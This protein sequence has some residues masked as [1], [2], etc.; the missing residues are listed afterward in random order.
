MSIIY[1]INILY[2]LIL[3]ITCLCLPSMLTTTSKVCREDVECSRLQTCFQGHHSNRGHCTPFW[4]V[5][6]TLCH[7]R[8]QTE[9]MVHEREFW[10]RRAQ[11]FVYFPKVDND[12]CVVGF[13]SVPLL[14]HR[15]GAGLSGVVVS[16]ENLWREWFVVMCSEL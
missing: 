15:G 8:C 3:M 4:P 2:C 11:R 6:K 10:S 16:R 1:M 12:T 14:N 5:N 9:A 7:D 13:Q